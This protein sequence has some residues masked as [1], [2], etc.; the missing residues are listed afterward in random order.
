MPSQNIYVQLSIIYCMVHM[1]VLFSLFYEYRGSRRRFWSVTGPVIGLLSAVFVYLLVTRGVAV[2]GQY[3]LVLGAV[4]TLLLF[5][6]FAKDRNAK[7][8]FIFCLADTV[9]IWLQLSSGLIDYAV[10]GGGLVTLFLRVSAYPVLEYVV[11]RWLRRPSW[12]SET[13]SGA[14]GRCSRR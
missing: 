2:M 13:P 6:A 1:L 9:N 3:G 11:W 5:F 8:V 7:F 14:A 12:R 10:G 4:P